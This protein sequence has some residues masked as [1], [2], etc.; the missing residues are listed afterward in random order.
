M[1]EGK[2]APPERQYDR[3]RN[4]VLFP[5][6][7]KSRVLRLLFSDLAT[8]ERESLRK[9]KAKEMHGEGGSE[10][11]QNTWVDKL[12]V[13]LGGFDTD[14]VQLLFRHALKESDFKKHVNSLDLTAPLVYSLDEA[15]LSMDQLVMVLRDALFLSVFGK[16]TKEA[17]EEMQERMTAAIALAKAN[18]GAAEPEAD[19]LTAELS[20]SASAEELSAPA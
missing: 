10:Q 2:S 4:A 18:G 20:A 5:E 9:V 14:M 15:G 6:A 3:N 17:F 7:G 13:M 11:T 8:I 16:T 1:A 19:P 12:E